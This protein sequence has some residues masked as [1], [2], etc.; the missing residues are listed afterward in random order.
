MTT[1]VLLFKI[2]GILINRVHLIFLVQSIIPRVSSSQILPVIIR[3]GE[4]RRK[5]IKQ[6]LERRDKSYFAK[7]GIDGISNLAKHKLE[8]RLT[9]N[10]VDWRI[11]AFVPPLS[12]HIEE[13]IKCVKELTERS[14]ARSSIW[15]TVFKLYTRLDRRFDSKIG[16]F[17]LLQRKLTKCQQERKLLHR[18]LADGGLTERR[19]S[20]LKFEEKFDQ[21]FAI[22]RK[23]RAEDFFLSNETY[24]LA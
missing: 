17:S 18:S 1:K 10:D 7:L 13:L 22:T 6:L 15:N 2:S 12:S 11:N 20:K 4:A 21:K 5:P 16:C 8:G 23:F 14:S 3:I 9:S 24:E 19:H